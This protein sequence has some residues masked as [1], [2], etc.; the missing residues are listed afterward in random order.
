MSAFVFPRTRRAPADVRKFSAWLPGNCYRTS[1]P[2]SCHPA[3]GVS[4]GRCRRVPRGEV[5]KAASTGEYIRSWPGL[6][7]M[8]QCMRLEDL[9]I[10]PFHQRYG[11]LRAYL[12]QQPSAHVLAEQNS[13]SCVFP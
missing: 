6:D 7:V 11:C 5:E 9:L 12:F 2:W 1:S 3:E 8:V 10:Q 13:L 4:R